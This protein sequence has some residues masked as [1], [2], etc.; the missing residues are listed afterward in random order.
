MNRD[1]KDH[2]HRKDHINKNYRENKEYTNQRSEKDYKEY[3]DH[4]NLSEKNS[5]SFYQKKSFSENFGKNGLINLSDV[6][7]R[8]L[9]FQAWLQEV[10]KKSL[11]D[12]TSDNERKYLEEFIQQYNNSEFPSK[13]YYDI[14]KYQAKAIDKMLRKRKREMDKIL[15]N[16]D[17]KFIIRDET[18]VFDDE[19]Q[20]EKEKKIMKELEQKKKLEEAIYTMNKSK[21]EAMKELDFK[22]N[23]MRHLYQTGDVAG[24]KD[25]YNQHFNKNAEK[26]KAERLPPIPIHN[27]EE[28]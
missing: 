25:I 11:S 17:S 6:F 5:N 7:T 18:F 16:K 8:K 27:D 3:R 2:I 28:E 15:A 24:A 9:E 26:E 21:A 4:R 22:G 19:G 20:K 23:L 10:K 12:I 1:Y 13:K 14:I